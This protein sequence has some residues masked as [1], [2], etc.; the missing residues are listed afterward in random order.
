MSDSSESS[1][2]SLSLDSDDSHD[3]HDLEVVTEAS[4]SIPTV[5]GTSCT[6]ASCDLEGT[7]SGQPYQ[8]MIAKN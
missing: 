4:L 5:S 2:D 6:A 1:S 7:I 8:H 3:D